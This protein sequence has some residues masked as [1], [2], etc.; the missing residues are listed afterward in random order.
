MP[1]RGLGSRYQ[2]MNWIRQSTRL[3]VYLRDGLA[4]AW[5]GHAVEEGAR[6]PLDHVT[7]HAHGGSDRP[8]NLVTCCDVCNASRGSL[9]ARRFA[10]RVAIETGEAVDEIMARIRRTV[11][12]ALPR[13]EAREMIERRGSVARALAA[14]SKKVAR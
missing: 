3:A 11:R 14:K 2:G 8:A 4:C 7:C 13:A 12:R 9:S 10:S 1:A 6:L 5:C